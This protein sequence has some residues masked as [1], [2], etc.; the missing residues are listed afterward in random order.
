MKKYDTKCVVCDEV[1]EQPTDEGEEATIFFNKHHMD[2]NGEDFIHKKHCWDIFISLPSWEE[3][4]EHWIDTDGLY[5]C[6]CKSKNPIFINVESPCW[7]CEKEKLGRV[8][9]NE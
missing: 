5:C 7:F 3:S 6:T 9:K 4:K 8:M 1:I 2:L